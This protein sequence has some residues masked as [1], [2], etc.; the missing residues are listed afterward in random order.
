MIITKEREML[1]NMSEKIM[2]IRLLK[3]LQNNQENLRNLLTPEEKYAL[4]PLIDASKRTSKL[5][6]AIGEGRIAFIEGL[7]EDKT[8]K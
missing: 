7:K 4:E 5:N 8:I 6:R 1:S 2:N 3:A